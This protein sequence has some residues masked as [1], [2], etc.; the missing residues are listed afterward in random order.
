[1]ENS[2]KKIRRPLNYFEFYKT[3]AR[4]G[5]LPSTGLCASLDSAQSLELMDLFMPFGIDANVFWARGNELKGN[6]YHAIR[7]NF[8][9]LRQNIVLLLAA[10][11]DQI[12]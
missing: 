7:Y 3:Y 2:C 1:M 8:N 10:M 6:I 5:F 11:H 4:D 12:K 9:P